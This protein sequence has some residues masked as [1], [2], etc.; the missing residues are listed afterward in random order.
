MTEE[1]WLT[2]EDVIDML[3]FVKQCRSMRRKAKQRKQWLFSVA[4]CRRIWSL[5]TNEQSR[6]SIEVVER[7]ADGSATNEEMQAA[8]A[9][10]VAIW[11]KDAGNDVTWACM[12][13]CE[14]DVNGMHVSTATISAVF[15]QLQIE[16]NKPF[17]PLDG[18][19]RG[20]CPQEEKEQC[21][22]LRCIFGNPFRPVTA[23][24]SWLTST[25]VALAR[26]IYADRAFDRLPILADALQDAGWDHPDILA[27][28]RGP[29]PHARGCWV[30][31]LVLG[32]E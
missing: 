21:Q 8:E 17:D 4:C 29:G 28:C 32:K 30:V 16:A 2:C 24:P 22:L 18:R 27:H 15:K 6:H 10:A 13:V 26:G 5:L 31:D 3:S 1:E 11:M 20:A 25:V 12:K 7:F 23:D 19:R 9:N 14:Q